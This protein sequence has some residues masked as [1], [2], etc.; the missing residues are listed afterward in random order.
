MAENNEHIETSSN[1]K[2]I[3]IRYFVVVGFL[4]LI[5]IGILFVVFKTS[6]AE[7]GG[8]NEAVER[9]KKPDLLI[10]SN[11]GNIYSSD[12][13]LLVT[14]TPRFD[15]YMDFK[16]GSFLTDTL[17]HSNDN[18]IDSLAFYLSK[19]LK[20]RSP[21]GYKTHLM[22][23]LNLKHRNYRISAEKISYADLLEIRR[24]PFFRCGSSNRTGLKADEKIQRVKLFG[25]L[26]SRTIG[27]IKVVKDG[28]GRDSL[29][30]GD[31]GL[32]L[33]YDSLL[34]GQPGLYSTIRVGERWTNVTEIEPVDGYDILTTIDTQI[35][36]FTEKTLLDKLKELDAELGIAIVMEVKTGEIKA[37]SNMVRTQPG[38]YTET[39]N[40]AIIDLIEPGSTFK[41]AAMMV[42]MED[43]ICSPDSV[44]DTGNGIFY[45]PSRKY[46]PIQDHNVNRG[47][48]GRL[49]VAQT[50][51]NSSNVGL[52]KV[53]LS[54]YEKNPS[55]FV[56]GLNRTGIN[57]DLKLEIQGAAQAR[58]RTPESN[59]WSVLSLTRMS[60]GY[61]VQIPPINTLAFYNAIANDGKLIQPIFTKE[62][63]KD[64]KAIKRFTAETLRPS[65]CS[66]E[67]L[68]IIREM[69]RNVV[70]EGTGK[71][72]RS[73]SV[74]FAGKTGTARIASG[75]A[76]TLTHNLSFC[77]YFPA[78]SPQYSCIVVIRR[79]RYGEPSG[80]M[81]GSVFKTIAEK[82][83]SHQTKIELRT[84]RSD[85]T[86]I[87]VPSTKNGDTK[88]LKNV[89]DEL[90]IKNNA[91]QIR[92]EYARIELR[93]TNEQIDL[94][95][96]TFQQ[97]RVPNVVGM[98]A[99]DAIYTLEKSGLRVSVTGRGQVVS[100][101]VSPGQNA[102][103]GQTV[104]LTLN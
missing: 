74:P 99:K 52:A 45:Y 3:L 7:K 18:G 85:S 83:Y 90:K 50:M 57:A 32:E 24:F 55:K 101:S 54:G 100:Q 62:I 51:W 71:P 46:P 38:R 19:L 41:V 75:G 37:I 12:R 104:A 80:A 84:M 66:Q 93:Q 30:R 21:A 92:T 10:N 95:E 72:F 43:K 68:N 94:Q 15:L 8:W 13:K 34:R 29:Y 102:N 97:G 70:E 88:A 98:G 63:Q 58:I 39:R 20:D 78:E 14:S 11:R 25:S 81:P 103:R 86:R 33:Q 64:G 60:F 69:L 48:Y 53:I 1:H 65:I 49:T 5:A 28:Q 42:A 73:E 61:E 87:V 35:Q 96:L 76:F 47:G 4:C 22:R 31:H 2:K 9:L 27:D 77:G 89:L 6:I 44:I 26:A 59:L 17:L 56:E 79:P 91:R 82:V 67:T 36:D 23:G 40:H 16:A